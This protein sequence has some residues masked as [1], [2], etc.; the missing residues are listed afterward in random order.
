MI[1]VCGAVF[2]LCALAVLAAPRVDPAVRVV[3]ALACVLGGGGFLVWF[4]RR[5]VRAT[6][7]ADEAGLH[8][9]NGLSTRT[10]AW[11]EVEGFAPSRWPFLIAVKVKGGRRV[12][13]AGITPGAFGDRGP[14]QVDLGELE[15]YWR[16]MVGEPAGQAN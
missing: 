4:E 14:Q 5:C 16:R 7:T 15:S 13:M 9:Y 11:S 1:V 8:V 12:T 2:L 10:I 6:V 3:F